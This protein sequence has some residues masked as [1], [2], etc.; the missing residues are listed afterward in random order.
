MSNITIEELQGVSTLEQ[1]VYDRCLEIMHWIDDN[2]PDSDYLF[3]YG[4]AYGNSMFVS[5]EETYVE[6]RI[7]EYWPYG[8]HE[9]HYYDIPFK[10][11]V[12]D[13]WHEEYLKKVEEKRI[14]RERKRKQDEDLKEK[15]KKEQERKEYERLKAKYELGLLD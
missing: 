2:D 6:V 10:W 8:G 1:R 15:L 7:E 9:T 3:P 14:E 13:D 12:D 5:I 4:K 11:I